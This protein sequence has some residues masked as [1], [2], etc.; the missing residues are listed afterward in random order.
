M[1]ESYQAQ[2]HF[3]HRDCAKLSKMEL[4]SVLDP[5]EA[6]AVPTRTRMFALPSNAERIVSPDVEPDPQ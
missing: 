4:L 2:G 6:P 5:D 3:A 1:E